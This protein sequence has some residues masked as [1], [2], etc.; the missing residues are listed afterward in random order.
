MN[1]A[2]VYVLGWSGYIGSALVKR[3]LQLDFS[4]CLVGRKQESD[5]IFN[6]EEPDFSFLSKI[7]TGDKFVFLSAISSPE[8][9]AKNFEKAF[10][11]NVSNTC[12]L[13][14]A[15]LDKGAR[16]LFASSDVVYGFTE[17]P[18]DENNDINPQFAY[19]EMKALVEN[20]Y[21]DSEHF[22]SMRLSYVWS[23][24][25]KFTQYLLECYSNETPVEV[26]HPF[27]RS[28]VYLNDVIEFVLC[29][30]RKENGLPTLVNLAGPAFLSRAEMV[31]QF[32]KSKSL[33]YIIKRPAEDFFIYRPEQIFMKSIYF[34]NILER[35]ATNVLDQMDADLLKL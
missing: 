4:P 23:L 12:L 21:K 2:G 9:C 15:L 14:N 31:E 27:I 19:A 24:N 17:T 25:D 11:I 28:V 5:V 30:L 13:I 34:E 7:L 33:E 10:K 1:S 6:L 20:K 32:S 16:V 18:V 3:I 26:F 22:L 29:F 35:N 8:V